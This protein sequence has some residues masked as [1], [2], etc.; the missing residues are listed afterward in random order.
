MS[1][2]DNTILYTQASTT[3]ILQLKEAVAGLQGSGSANITNALIEAFD[4]LDIWRFKRV[5]RYEFLS[6]SDVLLAYAFV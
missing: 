3:N 6:N 2:L 1:D 4:R 5:G